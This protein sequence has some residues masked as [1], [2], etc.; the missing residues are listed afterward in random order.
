MYISLLKCTLPIFSPIFPLF[1]QFAIL[2]FGI[3]YTTLV[4]QRGDSSYL[5]IDA[6]YE[7]YTATLDYICTHGMYIHKRGGENCLGYVY[8]Y[9]LLYDGSFECIYT[10]PTALQ[11][12]F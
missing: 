5:Y 11:L 6:N 9:K 8:I 4:L 2:N 12:Y 3:L 1:R 7:L 10:N